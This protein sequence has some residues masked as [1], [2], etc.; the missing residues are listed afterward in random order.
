MDS[1][2]IDLAGKFFTA[3]LIPEERALLVHLFQL[4]VPDY[5]VQV[6]LPVRFIHAQ[7]SESVAN[8]GLFDL[9]IKRTVCL[10]TWRL[11][12]L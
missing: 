7:N 8:D 11:V 10:E 12:D 2:L 1:A 6:L 4:A 9:V 5:P 3:H